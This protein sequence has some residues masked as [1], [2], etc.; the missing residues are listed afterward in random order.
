MQVETTSEKPVKSPTFHTPGRTDP[1]R[2]CASYRLHINVVIAETKRAHFY[3]FRIV[4]F[5]N[6]GGKIVDAR[7]RRGG[8]SF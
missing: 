7:I 2:I 1:G 3:Y 6:E 8:D 4:L 5:T